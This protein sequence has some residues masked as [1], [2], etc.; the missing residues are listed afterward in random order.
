MSA[1]RK[2]EL[3]KNIEALRT[4]LHNLH[5]EVASWDPRDG[6]LPTYPTAMD[7]APNEIAV[8]YQALDR[9]GRLVAVNEAWRSLLGYPDAEALGRSFAEFLTPESAGRFSACFA[10]LTSEARDA[11]EEFEI[12]RHDGTVVRVVAAGRIVRDSE[13]S[14]RRIHCILHD[15]TEHRQAQAALGCRNLQLEAIRAVAAEVTRELD[16]HRLLELIARRA[17]EITGGTNCGIYLWDEGA[18]VL[19]PHAY[20][21]PASGRTRYPRR[22]GEGVIGRVARERQG[23]IV[24]D[25]RGSPFAHPR[26]LETTDITAVLAEPLLYRD[27]LLGVIAVDHVGGEA[28][29]TPQDQDLLALLADQAAT[30]IE[31]ARLFRDQQRAYVE[32][33]QAQD[34]LI[35]AGKLRALGQMAAGIAHDLNNRLAAILGQTEL[36]KLHDAS[37]EIRE[38]LRILETAATDGATVVR[39]LQE[40]A[41][42]DSGTTPLSP[43]ELPDVV[44]E[45]MELTRPRWQD[46]PRRRGAVITVESPLEGLPRVLGNPSE[47]RDALTNLI[48]NAVDAMPDGGTISFGGTADGD[49]VVLAVT[50]TGIGMS[51]DVLQRIFEPF[52]TTKGVTGSGLGLSAVYGCMIRHGGHVSATSAPGR[53]T[54]FT[55]RFRVAPDAVPQGEA[56]DAVSRPPCRLLVIDDEPLVRGT[57]AGL[58]RAAGHTV[59]EAADGGTGLAH[60][61]KISVDCVITD[62][63]MPGMTGWEVARAIKRKTPGLPV[64]LLTGWADQAEGDAASGVVDRVLLKPLRIRDLLRVIG[65]VTGPSAV[66]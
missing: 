56:A 25:Y 3:L 58:L 14:L 57:V 20:H 49:G 12:V 6:G 55:L 64:L 32:L 60:L 42:Q 30:A 13:G 26:T 38:A 34:E 4:R 46:E 24:N 2:M 39:R 63:G 36:A 50:D 8:P 7:V 17:V 48:F 11:N 10:Q 59:V 23:T 31:N 9:D 51:A 15:I 45:A 22:P 53:G 37:P 47:I 1:E 66:G 21:G 43:V 35:R 40:F 41:R 65:D 44:R 18:E 29:F 62:L 27:R 54:T 16:S 52:F 19:M 61:A 33:Q 28:T 5:A